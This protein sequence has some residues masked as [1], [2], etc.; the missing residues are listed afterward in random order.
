MS[1]LTMLPA[2]LKVHQ[3]PDTAVDTAYQPSGGEK[4]L[5]LR[6]R[7]RG[8]FVRAVSADQQLAACISCQETTKN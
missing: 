4:D 1:P 3:K 6:R 2:L 8:V 7:T 5:H